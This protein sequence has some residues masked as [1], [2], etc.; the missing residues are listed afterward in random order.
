MALSDR[1]SSLIPVPIL[2]RNV[3]SADLASQALDS[4]LKGRSSPAPP[5]SSSGLSPA[6]SNHHRPE[7][8]AKLGLTRLP[9]SVVSQGRAL[10]NGSHPSPPGQLLPGPS[11][12]SYRS[13]SASPPPPPP[14]PHSPQ[15]PGYPLLQAPSSPN[16]TNQSSKVIL[17]LQRALDAT[18]E[19]LISSQAELRASQA[20]VVGLSGDYERLKERSERGQ[21]ETEGLNSVVARKERLLQ[22]T[23][24]RARTAE[25]EAKTLRDAQKEEAKSISTLTA[26][27][28]NAKALLGQSQAAYSTLS[29]SFSSLKTQWSADL[30]LVR[31]DYTRLQEQSL[32]LKEQKLDEKVDVWE[33]RKE[34]GR[35]LRGEREAV[36]REWERVVRGEV[37]ELRSRVEKLLGAGEDAEDGEEGEEG[38]RRRVEE[39]LDELTNLRRMIKKG[40]GSAAA[41]SPPI[42]P[43][44][45][46]SSSLVGKTSSSD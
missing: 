22:E 3:G 9:I 26:S 14:H 15:L 2:P 10:S 23:L 32:S 36:G 34:E 1:R 18:R 25:L 35:R 46:P 41:A 40:S 4:P 7:H 11:S 8:Y 39:A 19:K 31:A 5:P 27:L 33:G 29:S 20:Q 30:A 21:L 12:S 43:C 44:P 24:E 37:E 45:S 13:V 28:S 6:T 16:R 38:L 42:S 17:D